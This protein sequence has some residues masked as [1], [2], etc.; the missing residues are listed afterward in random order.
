[1][2]PPAI[3][4]IAALRLA[5]IVMMHKSPHRGMHFGPNGISRAAKYIILGTLAAAAP[6][7]P[8]SLPSD[9]M[10]TSTP[11]WRCIRWFDSR[12]NYRSHSNEPYTGAY[13]IANFVWQW[14]LHLR[15]QAWQYPRRV[16]NMAA[17]RLWHYDL[18]TWGNPW[19]AWETAPLCGL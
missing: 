3:L 9:A 2:L 16:Q 18:R 1:L 14:Q 15:G 4:A 5:L 6:L 13:Q 12:D 7:R 11:H 17:L 10:S 19:H 8:M